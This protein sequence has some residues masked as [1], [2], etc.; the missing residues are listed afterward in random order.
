MIHVVN[1]FTARKHFWQSTDQLGKSFKVCSNEHDRVNGVRDKQN[2]YTKLSVGKLPILPN[3][4]FPYKCSHSAKLPDT[5]HYQ[6]R[7]N[8][9]TMRDNPILFTL[10]T[11]TLGFL[12]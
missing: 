4:N 12:L 9:H 7:E 3:T 11:N 1:S 10:T 6:T 2:L 5:A 8:V